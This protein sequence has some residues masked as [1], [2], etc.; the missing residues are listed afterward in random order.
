MFIFII[1]MPSSCRLEWNPLFIYLFLQGTRKRVSYQRRLVFG[2]HKADLVRGGKRGAGGARRPWR[3]QRVPG[4]VATWR[5]VG[6][7]DS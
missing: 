1:I 3:G 6:L 4:I 7:L 5:R 2:R